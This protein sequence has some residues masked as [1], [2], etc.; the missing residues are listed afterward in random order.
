MKTRHIA[1]LAGLVL[2]ILVVASILTAAAA[3]NTVPPT[4]LTDK[5]IPIAAND[6]KPP[7]C[8]SFDLVSIYVCTKPNCQAPRPDALVIGTSKTNKIDGGGGDSCCVGNPNI[9]YSNC[10]WH[11]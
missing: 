10:A 9:F 5:T 11:P 7:Q 8:K 3:S 6:V 2:F 4:R 1:W